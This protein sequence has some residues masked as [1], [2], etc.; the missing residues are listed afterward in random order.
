LIAQVK[1]LTKTVA[2]VR[3]QREV[4]FDPDGLGVVAGDLDLEPVSE[5]LR[6]LEAKRWSGALH[7]T[8]RGFAS[9]LLVLDLR[10]GALIEGHVD[11]RPLT[12][13]EALREAL[14]W[15]GRRFEL[16][17]RASSADVE[18]HASLAELLQSVLS[19]PGAG[20]LGA[21]VD[22][23]LPEVSARP[24]SVRSRLD[25]GLAPPPPAIGAAA[26]ATDPQRRAPGHGL[27]ESVSQS[28]RPDPR[29]E[30]DT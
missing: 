21:S 3:A 5:V 26:T 30:S 29:A 16:F 15:S 24:A 13:M 9:R 23:D 28:A 4:L 14:A 7:L 12:A 1:A 2:R 17:P 19:Q 10:S 11:D 27:V 25:A 8:D 6:A 18:G 20:P 22:H